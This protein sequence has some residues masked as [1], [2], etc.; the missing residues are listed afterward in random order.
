MRVPRVLLIER[1]RNSARYYMTHMIYIYIYK[2]RHY[3]IVQAWQVGSK[4]DSKFIFK[5][6]IPAPSNATVSCLK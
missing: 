6:Y 3:I 2:F 5:T 4:I 1:E